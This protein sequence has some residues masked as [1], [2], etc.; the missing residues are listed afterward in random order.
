MM[1]AAL[2]FFMVVNLPLSQLSRRLTK[3][4]QKLIV[5]LFKIRINSFKP[6]YAIKIIQKLLVF[7]FIIS[8][9]HYMQIVIIYNNFAFPKRVVSVKK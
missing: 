5:L 7:V 9:K 4:I 6:Y 3:I 2:I 1:M 8:Q